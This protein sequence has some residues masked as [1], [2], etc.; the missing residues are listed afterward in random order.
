AV[1]DDEAMLLGVAEEG[2]ADP[3]QIL[4]VLLLDRDARTDAGM[5]EEI[6][7]E[8]EGVGE[9]LEELAMRARHLGADRGDRLLILHPP[10]VVDIDAVAARAFGA[11]IFQP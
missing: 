1:D 6:V 9:M 7:P 3:A 11:A 10:E 8:G 4:P 2:L 5:D